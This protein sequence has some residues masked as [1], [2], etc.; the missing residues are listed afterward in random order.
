MAAA[1]VAV[2]SLTFLVLAVLEAADVSS[3]R[4]GLGV[5]TTLF[6]LVIGGGIAWAAWRVTEGDAWARS[7]LVLSQIILLGLAWNFR[8][9]P[10]WLSPLVAAPAVVVLAALLS[11]PV[12]RALSGPSSV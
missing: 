11:P 8:G 4:V 6:L 12:T 1:V 10:P 3:E 7:P 5:G 2:E 9:D